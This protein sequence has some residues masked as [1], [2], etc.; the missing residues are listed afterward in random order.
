M[1]STYYTTSIPTYAWVLI[2]IGIALI[3]SLSIFLFAHQIKKKKEKAG[4]DAAYTS[5]LI[6]LGGKEN[7]VSYEIKMSRIHLTFHNTEIVQEEELKKAG[8]SRIIK[9]EKKWI[10]LLGK[11]D[12]KRFE[13][14]LK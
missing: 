6:A 1:I 4:R 2:G 8:V 3:L 10:L 5:I 14:Y 7:I 12:A 9:M 11:E 13:G